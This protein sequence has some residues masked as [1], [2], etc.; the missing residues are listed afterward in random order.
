MLSNVI[1]NYT[2]IHRP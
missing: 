1:Q 2:Q